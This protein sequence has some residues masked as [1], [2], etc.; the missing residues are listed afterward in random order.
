MTHP[1]IIPMQFPHGQA[2]LRAIS[3]ATEIPLVRLTGG[4]RNQPLVRAR[5]VFCW[6]MHQTSG[7]SLPEIGRLIGRDHTT[8]MH[9]LRRAREL[10]ASD[11]G[12]RHW[13]DEL[14]ARFGE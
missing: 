1:N 6:V 5:W 7:Y 8:I 4:E 12:F 13:T 14:A 2:V 3:E 9:G 11:P 10:R